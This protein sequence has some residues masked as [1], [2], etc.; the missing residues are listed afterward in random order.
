MKFIRC[1]IIFS[2]LGLVS[3][4]LLTSCR[5]DSP[6][7][8]TDTT[9]VHD[10]S[11]CCH[12]RVT[13]SVTDSATGHALD[14]GNASL[15]EGDHLIASKPMN[16][17][18]TVW[19]GLCP[20]HYHM[21]ISKDGYHAANFDIDSLTC[22][23]TQ[24]V[25]HTL[26]AE[27]TNSGDSCCSGRDYITAEDSSTHQ[28]LIGATIVLLNRTTNVSQTAT[29]SSITNGSIRF[30]D[31]CP[32]NYLCTIT[33]DGYNTV[34]F[35]W[36]QTCDEVLSFTKSL[37]SIHQNN[38]TCT[39]GRIY[40]TVD[41]SST[42]TSLS[43]ATINIYHAGGA[44]DTT[45]YSASQSVRIPSQGGLAPG[46]YRATVNKDGYGEGVFEFTITCNE[47]HSVTI[48]LLATTTTNC[49]TASIDIHVT[50]SLHHD[51][52][53]SGATVTI[54]MDGHTDNFTSGTTSDAGY[55]LSD[56]NLPGHTTYIMTISKDGY[57]TKSIVWQVT[58]CRAY[59]EG[60]YL[61]P[62]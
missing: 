1:S 57:N 12:G 55:Y 47:E 20:G 23:D 28:V 22:N 61:S 36:M 5:H 62:N 45:V 31:L 39:N 49:D 37:L 33:K 30:G 25:T 58:D 60:V 8:P 32:G 27:T 46:D 43:G 13:L 18:G 21:T 17:S 26:S 34:S 4:S 7:G 53:I 59:F 40:V 54:R 3:A 52:N 14:G 19:D 38:D 29:T 2:I 35:D 9:V 50:D 15:Y 56:H 24:K 6:T 41:D 51:V 48:S 16:D 44:L 10:T 42:H 11:G